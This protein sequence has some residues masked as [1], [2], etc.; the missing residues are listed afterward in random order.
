MSTTLNNASQPEPTLEIEN[1]L[2]SVGERLQTETTAVR[3]KI[4]WPS[5]RKTLSNDQNSD[6]CGNIRR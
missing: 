1:P 3:L 4:H 5:V 6:R 2:A